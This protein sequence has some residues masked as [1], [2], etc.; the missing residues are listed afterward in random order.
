MPISSRFRPAVFVFCVFVFYD[1]SF[2]KVSASQS[3]DTRPQKTV[4]AA[5]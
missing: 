4:I 1:A 5:A 2:D 3:A